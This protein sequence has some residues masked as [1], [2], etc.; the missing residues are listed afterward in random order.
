[1]PTNIGRPFPR[2]MRMSNALRVIENTR[3]TAQLEKPVS[4]F[5]D[6]FIGV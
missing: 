1:M 4:A 2:S 3:S 6:W 5:F